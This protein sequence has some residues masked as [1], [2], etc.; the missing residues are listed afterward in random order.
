MVLN[1]GEEAHSMT[2]HLDK[3]RE[4]KLNT[5]VNTLSIFLFF[6]PLAQIFKIMLETGLKVMESG[7]QDSTV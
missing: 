2:L 7:V 3:V 4:K 1:K 5:G 6:F